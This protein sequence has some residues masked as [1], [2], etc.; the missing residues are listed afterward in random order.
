M[1]PV[2]E[3]V[4]KRGTAGGRPVATLRERRAS[5][6]HV[7]GEAEYAAMELLRLTITQSPMRRTGYEARRQHYTRDAIS[8]I[9]IF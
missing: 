8:N 7:H 6:G 1:E 3:R 5:D 9:E 2:C 4:A